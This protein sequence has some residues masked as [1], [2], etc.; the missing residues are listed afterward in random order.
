MRQGLAAAAP[1]LAFMTPARLAMHSAQCDGRI[2]GAIAFGAQPLHIPSAGYPRAW[3]DMPLLESET[4]YEVWTSAQPVVR[5]DTVDLSSARDDGVLFGCLRIRLD[6]R[7]DATSYL[8]YSR[9]FDFIDSRGY[10]HLLRVWN[11]V[12]DINGDAD[13]LERYQHFNVGR[14]EAF[15]A[16]GRVIGTDTPA[17]CALGS[18]GNDLAVYFLA[19]KQPGQLVE[20]PRQTSAFHYPA[21]YGP[22]SPT[23]ARAMLMHSAESP[24]LFVSG[25]AS[26]VGHRTLHAGDASAQARETIANLRAVIAQAQLD[27][28]G[29]R[30]ELLMKAYLRNRSDM[31]MLRDA[32]KLAFGSAAR[33]LCL[34]ADI[35][36]ADLLLEVEAVCLSRTAAPFAAPLRQVTVVD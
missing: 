16:A 24:V 20:N 8:A 10:A 33:V 27:A 15:T 21:Q 6:R 23:F 36:R 17:A 31:P 22:R 3:V 13:G 35:C 32:L 18:R 7:L 19:A 5:E 25:T 26:I 4:A 1:A 14:H 11:Y 2:L 28:G 9:L 30:V 12:P 34:Q 29:A